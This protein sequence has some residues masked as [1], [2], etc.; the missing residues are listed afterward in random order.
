MA[1]VLSGAIDR[2]DG[3]A[4]PV[5]AVRPVVR[6]LPSTWTVDGVAAILESLPHAIFLE[7]GGPG[8]E[9]GA[10]TLLAFDPLW[11]VEVREGRLWR[12]PGAGGAATRPHDLGP[13]L[14]A[15][16]CAWPSRLVYDPPPP[17]PFVS[18]LAGFLAFD[19]KDQFE[20]YP[21]QA[22]REW[23]HPD[24]LLGFYDVV[25]GWNR[26]TGEAW[27]VATGSDG[28]V[29]EGARA[30]ERLDAAWA[31][32]EAALGDPAGRVSIPAALPDEPSW[33]D[34]SPIAASNFTRDAYLRIVERALEHIA[35]G[36]IYQ[37]NLSQRFWVEPAPAPAALYRRL[38]AVAPAP[39]L[40]YAA[41]PDGGAIASSSPERF[42]SIRGSRIESWPIKGTRPRG[43]SRA[44]DTAMAEALRGSE[45][46]RAE[47]V[48]IVDL[49]RNDLGRI[50]EV[51]SIRVPALWEVATHS[52]VHHLVSRVVGD[53]RGDVGPVEVLA[54]LFPGGSITGAPKIRAVEIIAALEPVRRGI[55][56]GAVG[57]W[58]ACG[59]ADWNIA[60]RTITVV[61][62]AASFHAGGGIVADSTPEGEYE[63]TLI[64]ASGM[65]R[66]LG[67]RDGEWGRRDPA[68]GYR[69]FHTA[70]R[71]SR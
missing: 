65:M 25:F 55:Y 39:F 24:L 48:M 43:R 69:S 13:A 41:L 59:D 5:A 19:L 49:V 9:S 40:A 23:P 2:A 50:C 47:N 21:M 45:K 44:E 12:L 16:R 68:L 46:D 1:G 42:F 17:I 54:A 29:A 30:A 36:D 8:R 56:T 31:R 10:W 60:I 66:A 63:E 52:N 35:A 27:A 67:V 34:L 3:A 71:F 11:Q 22:R 51:G 20:R 64:K 32:L 62:G 57:Y 58:D 70:S 38:R 37:V 4:R 6:P 18:G 28:R 26:E 15:L 7:S 14:D 33:D 61:G 53:L